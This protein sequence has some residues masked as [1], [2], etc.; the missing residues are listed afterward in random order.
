VVS[1]KLTL[2]WITRK[3]S[4]NKKK[5]KKNELLTIGSVYETVLIVNMFWGE[6][7]R[8]LTAQFLCH[9]GYDIGTLGKW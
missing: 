4:N 1:T 8:P 9:I 7:T 2:L 3:I 5:K 6:L